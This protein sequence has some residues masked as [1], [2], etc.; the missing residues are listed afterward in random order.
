MSV[1]YFSALLG[2]ICQFLCKASTMVSCLFVAILRHNKKLKT[3]HLGTQNGIWFG[4]GI[5]FGVKL[6]V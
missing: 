6:E 1:T 5:G 2:S 4:L 3:Q